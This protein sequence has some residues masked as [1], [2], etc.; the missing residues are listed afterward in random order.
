MINDKIL[1]S[2]E[3][4]PA[5]PATVQKVSG[6]LGDPDYS[7]PELV[8]VIEYDQAITAN[9]LR[10]C[11]SAYF[12]VRYKISTVREAVA[13]LG[14]ENLVRVVSA[15]GISRYYN[16]VNGY[17]QEATRLWE[18]SVGVAIMSL[19]LSKRIYN[20]ADSS[21]F[22]VGLLHDVG[23]VVLG[24]FVLDSF[25]QIMD[26][27][28]NHQYSFLEAEEE[29]IGINH[30][31]VGAKIALLWNFPQELQDAILYHHRPDLMTEGDSSISWLVYLA[32]Q[33]CMMMG[34]G[35]GADGLAY[36]GLREVVDRF[37]LRQR[38]FEECIV[39]L[40]NDLENAKEL[41]SL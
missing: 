34:I 15:A 38:D 30:A 8:G 20:R 13:Y 1:K 39:E 3:N 41:L 14:R 27:V 7:I 2:I 28:T 36:R 19:I 40:L 26:L 29:V 32:D 17:Y 31:E 18:H 16:K 24:E 10:M 23:K 6:L 37:K 11:N 35:G 9:I 22:T 25:Q 33:A 21:L 4:L 12:G 5:F